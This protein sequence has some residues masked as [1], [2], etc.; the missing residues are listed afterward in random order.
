VT[1]SD[2][3]AKYSAEKYAFKSPFTRELITSALGSEVAGTNDASSQQQALIAALQ[4]HEADKAEQAKTPEDVAST[5]RISATDSDAV[6][7]V[8][9]NKERIKRILVEMAR[10]KMI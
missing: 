9:Q 7:Y 2:D 5:V 8:M 4:Q 10:N 1:L 3:L 6:N